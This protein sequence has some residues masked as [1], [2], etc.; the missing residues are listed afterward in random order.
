M[1]EMMKK[2]APQSQANKLFTDERLDQLLSQVPSKDAQ[3]LLGETGLAGQLK[4]RLAERR[5]EAELSHHVK[6]Q[7]AP[8]ETDNHRNGSRAKT[9][10]TPAGD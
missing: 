3:S 1:N 4:K 10:I 5:L 9:V 7:S 2:N 8:G 6:Q